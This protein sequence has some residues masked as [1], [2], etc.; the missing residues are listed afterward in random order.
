MTGLMNAD[1]WKKEKERRQSILAGL[2]DEEKATQLAEWERESEEK[3]RALAGNVPHRGEEKVSELKHRYDYAVVSIERD[4]KFDSVVV[5]EA[6]ELI[7][8]W[9]LNG[10]RLHTYSQMA[11]GAGGF[12][13]G[14]SGQQLTNVLHLVFERER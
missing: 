6:H 11:L 3:S 12:A 13:R 10:W 7:N 14:F 9:A 8:E 4:G 2:S 1:E 5:Q